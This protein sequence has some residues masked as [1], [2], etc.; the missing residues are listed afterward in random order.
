M[1]PV[2]SQF[3]TD[4]SPGG[5]LASSRRR[6]PPVSIPH[7]VGA[8]E[9]RKKG[10]VSLGVLSVLF[11][12]FALTASTNPLRADEPEKPAPVVP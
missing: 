12:S 8:P 10:S 6:K 2:T 7:V 3:A 1:N 9:G 5:A 4:Q 11:V